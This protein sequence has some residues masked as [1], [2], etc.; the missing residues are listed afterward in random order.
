MLTLGNIGAGCPNN[1]GCVISD[2]LADARS[3]RDAS[4]F[5]SPVEI[6]PQECGGRATAQTY[7]R[8]YPSANFGTG[9]TAL[10]LFSR[11]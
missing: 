4:D 3:W 5:P 6:V 8:C 2:A 9:V 7:A 10:A 11:R 1:S